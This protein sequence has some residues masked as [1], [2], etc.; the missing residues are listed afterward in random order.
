TL[1]LYAR[2]P[3]F[4]RGQRSGGS[5]HEEHLW[6][7]QAGEDSTDITLPEPVAER[8]YGGKSKTIQLKIRQPD[9]AEGQ[10]VP[11]AL[12]LIPWPTRRVMYMALP[13]PN[14]SSQTF[15]IEPVRRSGASSYVE[16]F[17]LPPGT[18]SPWPEGHELR[19]EIR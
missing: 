2:V 5:D 6:Q 12:E 17:L 18:A 1:W 7:L 14:G 15:T 3:K 16:L 13:L 4:G 11:L 19:I 9:P 10:T 8:C